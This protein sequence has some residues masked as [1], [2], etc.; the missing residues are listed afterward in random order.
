MRIKRQPIEKSRLFCLFQIFGKHRWNLS[1]TGAGK[2]TAAPFRASFL[3]LRPEFTRLKPD[4]RIPFRSLEKFALESCASHAWHSPFSASIRWQAIQLCGIRSIEKL[5]II[6]PFS[7]HF[8]KFTSGGAVI[9][10]A[11]SLA[12]II[13][14]LDGAVVIISRTALSDMTL[15][16]FRVRPAI[17]P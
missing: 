4:I 6:T 1:V 13:A 17:P 5:V 12:H 10:E 8:T 9:I 3:K 7:A 16:S 2:D 11:G 14:R 15:L